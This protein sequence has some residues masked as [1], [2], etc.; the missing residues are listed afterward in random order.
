[1][2]ES[3]INKIIRC[4]VEKSIYD[5]EMFFLHRSGNYNP[6]ANHSLPPS[7][8]YVVSLI[9]YYLLHLPDTLLTNLS[10]PIISTYPNHFSTFFSILSSTLN[11]HPYFSPIIAFLTLSIL[12]MPH[13]FLKRI[14]SYFYF[15]LLL[16]T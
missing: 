7:I 15:S 16:C 9:H 13:M 1:M 8:F 5:R 4:L 6:I 12:F 3:Q 2:K 11:S 10:S 14:I